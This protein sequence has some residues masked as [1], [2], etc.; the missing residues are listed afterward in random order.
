[1]GIIK[2]VNLIFDYIRHD[3]EEDKDEVSHAL[4][5]VSLDIKEGDFVA[6]LG[7]LKILRHKKRAGGVDYKIYNKFAEGGRQL[8]RLQKCRKRRRKYDSRMLFCAEDI[9][10][11]Q[12]PFLY[13]ICAPMAA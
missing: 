5:G 8:G 13:E 12:E 3:E 4:K 11:Q 2:A 7:H 6:I 10:V 9:G 1:M